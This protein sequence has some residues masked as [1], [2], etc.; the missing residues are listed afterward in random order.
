MRDVP[1][2]G[3]HVKFRGKLSSLCLEMFIKET[4]ICNKEALLGE[5][6]KHLEQLLI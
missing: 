3:L 1:Y 5:S 2:L 6:S 4:E